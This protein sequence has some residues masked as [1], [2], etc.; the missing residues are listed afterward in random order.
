MNAFLK[1][2]TLQIFLAAGLVCG[3]AQSFATDVF[4]FVSEQY[5][6]SGDG[7]LPAVYS[8]TLTFELPSSYAYP[9]GNTWVYG[10]NMTFTIAGMWQRYGGSRTPPIWQ[11]TMPATD[12]P[13]IFLDT[14]DPQGVVGTLGSIDATGKPF[15]ATPEV[16]YILVN[17]DFTGATPFD[18][19]VL[20]Q[21]PALDTAGNPVVIAYRP[22]SGQF[23]LIDRWVVT[24]AKLPPGLYTV[25]GIA[26]DSCSSLSYDGK[27]CATPGGSSWSVDFNPTW[28]FIPA[29][30]P[31][32]YPE[33]CD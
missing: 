11:T 3:A 31:K 25:T 32:C 4:H 1:L 16:A 27:T 15:C 6:Y 5:P 2:Y 12:K 7:G 24:N 14:I 17:K 21:T 20:C 29:P 9:S 28:T 8:D 22:S 30:P 26:G 13:Q 23:G 19:K 33:G 10:N 18:G